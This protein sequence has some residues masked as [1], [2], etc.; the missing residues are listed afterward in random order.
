MVIPTIFRMRSRKKGPAAMRRIAYASVISLAVL[1]SGCVTRVYVQPPPPVAVQPGP[2]PGGIQPGPPPGAV[3]PAP[4]PDA[5]QPGPPPDAV[6]PGSPP[7]FAPA[8]APMAAPYVP[9]YY[10]WDGYEYVGMCGGQYVYWNGGAWL[11]CDGLILGRF[12]GWERYHPGWRR[13]AV[14]YRGWR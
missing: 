8:P 12:H 11:V 7:A 1:A 5:G 9:Q 3:Q 4:P 10:V 6:Q 13:G 2:P 14:R